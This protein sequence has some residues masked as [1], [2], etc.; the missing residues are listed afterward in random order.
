M[1]SEKEITRVISERDEGWRE[2]E[3]KWSDIGEKRVL[4]C[5][6]FHLPAH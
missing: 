6:P 2:R 4:E 3:G 5:T 1:A